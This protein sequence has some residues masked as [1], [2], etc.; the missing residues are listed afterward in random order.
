MNLLLTMAVYGIIGFLAISLIMSTGLE[1]NATYTIGFLAGAISATIG[2]AI[3][4]SDIYS[5]R[6]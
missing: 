3:N 1:L 5:K 6:Y 4:S 2:S